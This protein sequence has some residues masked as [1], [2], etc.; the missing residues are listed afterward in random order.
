MTKQIK[1]ERTLS[2]GHKRDT[3]I[4]FAL[5]IYDEPVVGEECYCRECHKIVTIKSVKELK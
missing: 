3:D 2:C 1:W 4:S 5:E